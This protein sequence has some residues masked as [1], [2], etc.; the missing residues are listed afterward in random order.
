MDGPVTPLVVG[1][2]VAGRTIFALFSGSA[3]VDNKG[4]LRKD[5]PM[6]YWLIIAIGLVGSIV[7]FAT[8]YHL[9]NGS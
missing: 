7:L 4:L 8:A 2:L 9:R 3:S 1:I 6:T 5:E